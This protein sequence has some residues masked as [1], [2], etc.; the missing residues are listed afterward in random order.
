MKVQD[1][2][3]QMWSENIHST[4]ERKLFMNIFIAQPMTGLPNE[5][6]ENVRNKVIKL[7]QSEYGDITILDQF[8]L[9][10]DIPEDY[11]TS[12]EKQ[13][14]LLGRSIQILAKAD[15]VVMPMDSK[16]SKGCC[17]EHYICTTY[18]IPIRYYYDH[19]NGYAF[20]PKIQYYH[21]NGIGYTLQSVLM[22]D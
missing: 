7:C 9:P 10:D 18:G 21:D 14:Y 4:S 11:E 17:V 5:S 22:L 3:N 13:L 20:Y 1:Y 8:H 15:V 6:I 16:I 12:I 2:V 19:D